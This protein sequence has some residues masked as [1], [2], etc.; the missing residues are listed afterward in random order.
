MVGGWR[1]FGWKWK[2]ITIEG[3]E[4]GR[5][6]TEGKEREGE[7]SSMFPHCGWFCNEEERRSLEKREVRAWTAGSGSFTVNT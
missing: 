2:S 6:G 7:K 3:R 4:R 1:F 5:E